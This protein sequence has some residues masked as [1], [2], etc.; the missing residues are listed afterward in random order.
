MTA[1][2]V[3]SRRAVLC[4]G[5]ALVVSF[6]LLSRGASAQDQTGPKLPSSLEKS[7]LLDAWIR[8]DADGRITVFTGKAELG[9]GIKTA[10][11]QIA[12]EELVV[13]PGA[14]RLVTA[15][16]ALTPDE[17]YTAGSHSLQDSGTAIR[18]AAAQARQLLIAA[19]AQQWALPTDRLSAENGAVIAKPVLTTPV[20]P[21][22]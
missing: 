21:A 5:G 17:G 1:K 7:P 6:S 11:I 4:G 19:A 10:L 20:A 22:R 8:I 3:F 18:H 12:A 13:A 15:D 16:T 2:V 9:Q 14:I